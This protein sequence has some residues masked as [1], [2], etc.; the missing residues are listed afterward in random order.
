M[1]QPGEKRGQK[2]IA[3]V[4]EEEAG[5]Q[6]G[7]EAAAVLPIDDPLSVFYCKEGCFR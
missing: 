6:N 4:K 7:D 1:G 3:K 5:G 2:K